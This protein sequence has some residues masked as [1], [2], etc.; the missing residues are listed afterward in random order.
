MEEEEATGL[1]IVHLIVEDYD[2]VYGQVEGNKTWQRTT[3]P[4]TRTTLMMIGCLLIFSPTRYEAVKVT[5][6]TRR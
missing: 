1:T 3:I 5:M 2:L 6:A 4:Q